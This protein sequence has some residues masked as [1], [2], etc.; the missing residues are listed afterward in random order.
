MFEIFLKTIWSTITQSELRAFYEQL[1][2]YKIGVF[3]LG[4]YQLRTKIVQNDPW[5]NFCHDIYMLAASSLANNNPC[6]I[7]VILTYLVQDPDPEW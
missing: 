3:I 5:C 7:I 2:Y 4:S 6:D 1:I